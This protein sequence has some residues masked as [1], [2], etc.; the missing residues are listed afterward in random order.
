MSCSPDFISFLSTF[1]ENISLNLSHPGICSS[2]NVSLRHE[3]ARLIVWQAAR[4]RMLIE[5]GRPFLS[6]GSGFPTSSSPHRTSTFQRIR[7]SNS[8]YFVF[9]HTYLPYV[10]G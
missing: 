2:L 1:H 6:F 8:G 9:S 10:S 4:T 5:G 3:V 7:R